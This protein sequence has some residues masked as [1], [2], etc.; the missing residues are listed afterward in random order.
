[1]ASTEAAKRVALGMSGGVDSA[2]AAVILMRAGYEVVGVTCRF[3]EGEATKSAEADAQA[4]CA[5]LGIEHRVALC[6]DEFEQCVVT[7]FVDQYAEGLTPSPC[8]GCNAT[9]KI[10]SLIAAADELNCEFVATGHY[11]RVAQMIDTGRFAIKT[12]LDQRKDQSYMLAMLRQDQLERLLLPL[13]GMTKTDVRLIAED[14]DLPVAHKQESQDICFIDGDYRSFLAER[15]VMCTPGDIVTV[16]GDV[17]G[18]HDGLERFTV[19][20]RKGIG[21]AAPKPY[22]VIE[23]RMETAELVVG[24]AEDARVSGVVCGQMNYQLVDRLDKPCEAQVKLRYRSQ[25]APCI[26]EPNTAGEG[27]HIVL[28]S[29]EAATSSGQFA[30]LYSGDTVLGAGMILEVELV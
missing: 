21:V 8:V 30:V 7:K 16:D 3:R 5:R 2:V 25:P 18:H 19:G 27:V 17:V 11:A 20:Q 15:G 12:A 29:P 1:M 22:Y 6:V 14:L 9:C 24:F 28:A 4:V 13:G 23:K 26:I 10:P